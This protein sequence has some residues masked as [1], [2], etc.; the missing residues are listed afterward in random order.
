MSGLPTRK[1]T[2]RDSMVKTP[3]SLLFS[4][5]ALFLL[6]LPT[7]SAEKDASCISCHEG[8]V[9]KGT[10]GRET[11]PQRL[12]KTGLRDSVHR[13]IACI[14]CH[15]DAAPLPHRRPP[16][17]VDCSGC[18]E[19]AARQFGRSVHG[20]A[21][22]R[23]DKD[24]PSCA[25]CHGE[26]HILPASDRRSTVSTGNL[27]ILCARCHTDA[28]VQKTHQLPSSDLIRAYENSVHGRLLRRRETGAG[29]RLHRLPWKPFDSRP[30]GS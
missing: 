24:A 11:V 14:D 18:H 7:F 20:A 9:F 26:H 19:E 13:T 8:Q 1:G 21:F 23:G 22:R 27:V 16:A 3:R 29:C 10:P 2:I 4:L 15:R 5:I 28:E 6:P 30:A 12:M 25:S 17:K